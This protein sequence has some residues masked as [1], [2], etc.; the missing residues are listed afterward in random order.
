MI[1]ER[2]NSM[3][4]HVIERLGQELDIAEKTIETVLSLLEENTVPFIARYRKEMTGGLNEEQLRSIEKTYDYQK[5]LHERKEAVIRL[6][7]EK[8]MLTDELK[9]SI[10]NAERIVD[11]EDLYR[12]YKEKR[13]TKA[14]I[15]VKKGLEPLAKQLYAQ[16]EDLDPTRAAQAYVGEKVETAEEALQGAM[17]IVSEWVS[18]HAGYRRHIRNVTQNS[19]RLVAKK[20]KNADDEQGVYEMYYDYNEPLR[21][22][23]LF[24]VLA[25]NR[26]EK[27]KVLR[28]KIEADEERIL[29]YLHRQVIKN[30]QSPA[31]SLL[32]EAIADAY[33]R[34]IRPS[35]EREVRGELTEKAEERA[36]HVFSEN[37]RN[38]LLQPPLR[39][40]RILG[41]DPAYRT[42]C[43]LAVV[44]GYSQLIATDVIYP[45]T[46]GKTHNEA[47]EKTKK[48]LETYRIDVVAIGNGTASRE[49]ERFIIDVF[50]ETDREVFYT[51]VNE[52]GASVYS[53]SELAKKEFPKLQV[54]ERSAVSIARRLQD[55]LSELVK[56]DPKS[57]GVGQYQHDITQSKL[58]DSLDFTVETVVNRVGV[59]VNTASPSLLE[60]VSG[61]SATVAKN[62]V[63]HRE[64][65]GPFKSRPELR[66]V[67]KLG[68]K[69]YEQSIGFM[70]ILDGENPL[71]KTPIHPESYT[72]AETMMETLGV[73]SGDLGNEKMAE[74]VAN[75]DIDS[76]LSKTGLGRPTVTDILAAFKAPLWDPREDAPAPILRSDV[77]SLEDLKTGMRLKGTVRNVVDFGAFVDCGVKEDGLVHISKMRESYVKHPLDVVKVGDVVEV[78]VEGVDLNRGRLQLS[79]VKPKT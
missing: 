76:L 56:I 74:A 25:L 30:P 8:D 32:E 15:A 13:K 62:I 19:G 42:G 63:A 31:K 50:K 61:I 6:I 26:G 77:L 35:I 46:G 72:E 21:G 57:I 36:I 68:E 10:L 79:M 22:I 23:K 73:S 4:R 18:D 75:A 34:L 44:D 51:I 2:M 54:E 48:I 59:N 64:A 24:R 69:T 39:N 7:D 49:T 71:D 9:A 3:N 28:V 60:Y 53:A 14:T 58:S 5:Q 65:N 27:E 29:H 66:E 41:V 1:P 40:K 33:K 47:L 17:H 37:L 43:K 70:R 20:I 55:P 12:P 38:L 52:A 11:V 78:F 45:H 67:A 16:P